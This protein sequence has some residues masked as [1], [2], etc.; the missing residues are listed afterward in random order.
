MSA[1][2]E[3]PLYAV[4]GGLAAPLAMA[5]FYPL[6][7]KGGSMP[8]ERERGRNAWFDVG[9]ATAGAVGAYAYSQK[10]D[11]TPENKAIAQGAAIGLATLGAIAVLPL[12][13]SD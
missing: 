10:Q 7:H 3:K 9:I 2:T 8:T 12:L 6:W 1:L 11:I 5:A 4:G 13:F